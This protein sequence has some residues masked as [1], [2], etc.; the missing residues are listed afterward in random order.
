MAKLPYV[1]LSSVD[2]S[3]QYSR[4]A[5]D[6]EFAKTV[7]SPV[8]IINY[9]WFFASISVCVGA[10]MGAVA[11]LTSFE[12]VDSI[13]M[14]YLFIFGAIMAV[15]ENPFSKQGRFVADASQ[16]VCR[17]FHLLTRVIGKSVVL[18]FLG[19]A[20]FSAMWTNLEGA[21]LL[22]FAVVL[23]LFTVTIG[24]LSVTIAIVK[25]L[26]LD[27]IRKYFHMDGEAI[28]HNALAS[29]YDKH[30]LVHPQLGMTPSEFNNLATDVRGLSFEH[31]DLPLIFNAL[32]SSPNK[33][34][35]TLTDLHAW[36]QG[37]LVLL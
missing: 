32:S 33:S 21:L 28:G 3:P 12:W 13:E 8:A 31:S 30:A 17:Y 27:N 11:C 15:L 1:Q 25:S 9:L 5:F 4:S 29:A 7:P 19:C 22:F 37:S 6:H 10:S 23:G 36:V 20:L 14:C 26:H 2:S 18:F 34:A 16:R 35:L 24:M